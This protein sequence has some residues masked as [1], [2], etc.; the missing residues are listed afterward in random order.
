MD[1]NLKAKL[2]VL[3]EEHPELD[4]VELADSLGRPAF[5]ISEC[6]HE[7]AKEGMIMTTHEDDRC[8]VCELSLASSSTTPYVK[9]CASCTYALLKKAK[10]ADWVITKVTTEKAKVLF[11]TYIIDKLNELSI[12][13]KTHD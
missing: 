13:H 8:H 5:E 1:T 4:D 3:L 6:L 2:L 10:F 11:A 12:A 7:I 9:V